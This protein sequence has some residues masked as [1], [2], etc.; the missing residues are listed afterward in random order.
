MK[1]TDQF[2]SSVGCVNEPFGHGYLRKAGQM[3][4]LG[5][6]PNNL[7][8]RDAAAPG[9]APVSMQF[10]RVIHDLATGHCY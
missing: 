5:E 3:E 7:A 10:C 4:L 2:G 6:T 9:A 8:R 1:F